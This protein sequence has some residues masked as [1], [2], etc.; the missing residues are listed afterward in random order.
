MAGI[1]PQDDEEEVAA[2][3]EP[4]AGGV[5]PA[6]DS[7]GPDDVSDEEGQAPNVSPEEQEQYDDFCHG[8]L[9]LIYE[10]DKDNGQV[11]PGILKLLDDDPSDL[12]AILNAKELEQ[13]SP[14]VAIAATAVVVV[15][16]IK[17]LAKDAEI[18]DAVLM[19][20]GAFVVEELA[21]IWMGSNKHDLSEDDLHKTYQ[22]AV[23]IYREVAADAGMLDENSL[24]EQFAEL[25]KADKEGRLADVSPEL[26]GINAAAEQNAQEGDEPT[27]N[28]QQE[29]PNGATV[30]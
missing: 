17:R 7:V 5:A 15:M 14:L 23:D 21:Q 6:P 29:E 2:P 27:D 12:K 30:S 3:E 26:A 11:K 10:G 16:E 19:H 8:A 24:K 20:G 9:A 25:Q 22:I 28:P 13:F 4:S 1:A 18:S